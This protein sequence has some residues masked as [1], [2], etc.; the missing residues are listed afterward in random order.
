MLVL[1]SFWNVKVDDVHDDRSNLQIF[2]DVSWAAQRPK[3]MRRGWKNPPKM[4]R[5]LQ[6]KWRW[7]SS[8][9]HLEVLKNRY[10][11]K[12]AEGH[13]GILGPVPLLLCF[14]LA[15]CSFFFDLVLFH[16]DV[17]F[18][19]Y[20][21]YVT[22]VSENLH[23]RSSPPLPQRG[24]P[25]SGCGWSCQAAAKGAKEAMIKAKENS[26]RSYHGCLK[27]CGR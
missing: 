15:L 17:S 20:S 23:L 8:N 24:A 11:V 26:V 6:R 2:S 9:R 25:F 5:R 19:C 18:C 16:A 27:V 10:G 22:S 21:R 3:N 13:I 4:R 7:D 14:A 1:T 12:G